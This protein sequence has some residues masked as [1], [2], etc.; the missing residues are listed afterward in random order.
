MILED[1]LVEPFLNFSNALSQGRLPG[2][3]LFAG[4]QEDGVNLVACQS[5]KLYLCEHPENGNPCCRCKSCTMFEA[6][7]HP[8]FLGV[9]SSS[10]E[11]SDSGLDLQR[12]PK[13]LIDFQ[14][15]NISRKSV[16]IDSMRKLSAWTVESATVGVKK[17]AIIFDAHTMP[18][19]AA[20][21]ILKTFE[22][23]PENTLI[24]M[25]A[26]SLESLLPTI[27]SRAYK[28]VLHPVSKEQGLKFINKHIQVDAKRAGIALALAS[29]KPY[30]ALDL[31]QSD[32]DLKIAKMLS[33]LIKA[34]EAKN[35]EEEA[36][37]ALLNLEP[38]IQADV[39]YK[40]VLEVLKY[41]AHVNQDSLPLIKMFNGE[42][43]ARLSADHLF[44]ALDDL[45][46]IK[47]ENPLI[48]SRTPKAL[49][50]SWIK[51]LRQ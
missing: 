26:R 3:V 48:P 12:D 34:L 14:K 18:E 47:A 51:A 41:K 29:G 28:I 25:T 38:S 24:I 20:N 36:I 35:S 39:L 11:E 15:N 49:L 19:G 44:L 1:F 4:S 8:D 5:A 16:R 32:E 23:P 27:L 6:G 33:T 31:L 17:V 7:S 43:L 50:R 30:G 45:R 13:V 21:A 10:K 42:S 37:D 9:L 2:S 40:L 22:E 46:Y